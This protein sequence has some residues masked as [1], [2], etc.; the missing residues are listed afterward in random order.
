LIFGGMV[1]YAGH[2]HWSIAAGIVVASI[3][4]SFFLF[5]WAFRQSSKLDAAFGEEKDKVV[6]VYA[7]NW[8]Y[9]D[10]PPHASTLTLG[11]SDGSICKVRLPMGVLV[12]AVEKALPDFFPRAVFG[13]REDFPAAFSAD[14]QAFRD[15]FAQDAESVKGEST[16]SPASNKNKRLY[17][18]LLR[19]DQSPT[20]DQMQRVL[21]EYRQR[22]DEV[23]MLGGQ[24]HQGSLPTEPDTIVVVTCLALCQE[25]GIDFIS[26]RDQIAYGIDTLDGENLGICKIEI[27]GR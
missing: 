4:I 23:T 18:Y 2:W 26:D 9:G 24:I 6:W 22:F 27:T 17:L 13:F 21:G 1:F 20:Q 14:P 25:E 3:L 8:V 12:D 16:S 7:I 11:L 19:P 10:A 15:K 5:R